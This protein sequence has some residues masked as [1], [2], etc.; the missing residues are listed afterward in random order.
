MGMAIAVQ[1]YTI[2]DL[3][4][5]PDDGKRY[6][7]L[8]GVLL[9]TPQAAMKHQLVASRIQALLAQ[10]IQTPGHGYVFGS[11]AV[12]R[13]P[14]TQLQ[15]DIHV[16]PSRFSPADGWL[17]VT[18]HWLVVEVLSPSSRVYDRD[19]KRGAYFAL[20]VREVWIVDPRKKTFE[21]SRDGTTRILKSGNF[22]WRS[23]DGG[24]AV[25]I[26]LGEIFAGID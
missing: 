4:S 2:E 7:L 12:I 5:F 18:E 6:E 8:D 14:N 21:I 15:P 26:E 13:P 23:P 11:G 19:L 16:I 22:E 20:G 3:E 17:N 25:M 1:R 24:L 9:V 10:V